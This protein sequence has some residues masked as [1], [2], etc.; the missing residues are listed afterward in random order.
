MLLLIT[1]SQRE[2]ETERVGE[3]LEVGEVVGGWE[4]GEGGER[5]EGIAMWIQ[6]KGFVFLYH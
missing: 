6:T 1:Q 3:S 2:T 5:I 4:L